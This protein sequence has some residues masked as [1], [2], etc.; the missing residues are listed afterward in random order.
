MKFSRRSAQVVLV[1]SVIA[2]A[3]AAFV[4]RHNATGP[5]TQAART[6]SQT[7][8]ASAPDA[9]TRNK[10]AYQKSQPVSTAVVPNVP[11]GGLG[12]GL[13]AGDASVG[14]TIDVILHENSGPTAVNA[15][16]ALLRYD[17]A[18][19]EYAGAGSPADFEIS[20][21]T[22]ASAA[23]KVLLARGTANRTLT[24][25]KR[26]AVLHFKTKSA[27]KAALSIDKTQSQLVR[28]ASA[29]DMLTAVSGTQITVK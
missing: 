18:V 19:L 5:G 24:G 20:A 27:G 8:P 17:P 12:L 23:G 29:T 3:A 6:T 7:S 11:E 10:T 26:V 21:A 16:Q 14:A 28:T 2:V 4:W 1:L 15:V 9:T 22:D 13:S 25:Q